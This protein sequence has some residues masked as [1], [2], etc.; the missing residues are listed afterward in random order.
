MGLCSV[1]NKGLCRSK[2]IVL[3]VLSLSVLAWIA[4]SPGETVKSTLDD[5]DP[6][7]TVSRAG[8]NSWTIAPTHLY[9]AAQKPQCP[10]ESP[11]LGKYI[12]KTVMGIK[13]NTKS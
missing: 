1:V 2:Y 5:F 8:L 4:M 12:L 6:T 7:K 3:L 10:E 9:T 11:F 13:M